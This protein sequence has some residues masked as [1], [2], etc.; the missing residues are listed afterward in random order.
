[1]DSFLQWGG[2]GGGKEKDER[3]EEGGRKKEGATYTQNLHTG[4]RDNGNRTKPP[5]PTN[6]AHHRTNHPYHRHDQ[7]EQGPRALHSHKRHT[8]LG[9]HAS[10]TH[11]PSPH[12]PGFGHGDPR[13]HP[14][15]PTKLDTHTFAMRVHAECHIR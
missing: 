11:A 7:Q 5:A 10:P 9:G 1:M 4:V 13:T 12:T 15:Q 8:P 2:R 6:H 14:H 3:K